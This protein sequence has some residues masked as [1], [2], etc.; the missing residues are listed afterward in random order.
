[1]KS[2]EQNGRFIKL[3]AIF[4]TLFSILAKNA[5]LTILALAKEIARWNAPTIFFSPPAY[6]YFRS[7]FSSSWDVKIIM[8]CVPVLVCTTAAEIF[9]ETLVISCTTRTYL[10]FSIHLS[11]HRCWNT[12]P[13]HPL[14]FSHHFSSKYDRYVGILFFQNVLILMLFEVELLFWGST[15]MSVV[16]VC[17]EPRSS[18]VTTYL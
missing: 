8:G 7:S 6:Y 14:T 18:K 12:L 13:P 9:L 11:S 15:A 16:V 2:S 5:K 3:L 10:H 17:C 1:M 4:Q